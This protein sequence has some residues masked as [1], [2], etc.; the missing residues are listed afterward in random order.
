[1]ASGF[2]GDTC[3]I[4]FR[5]DKGYKIIRYKDDSLM[6]KCSL[7]GKQI[8]YYTAIVINLNGKSGDIYG[9]YVNT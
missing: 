5:N 1:M 4:L 9:R 3:H 6:K 2:Y 7:S 8:P